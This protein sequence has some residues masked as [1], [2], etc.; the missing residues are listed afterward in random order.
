MCVCV[1]VDITATT[2]VSS[3]H[4]V[5]IVAIDFQNV[6]IESFEFY[7]FVYN[8]ISIGD[9]SLLLQCYGIKYLSR[10]YF[11]YQIFTSVLILREN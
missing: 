5:Y 11:F 6:T 1:A 9:S 7:H 4:D 8:F 10:K 3:E 2:I